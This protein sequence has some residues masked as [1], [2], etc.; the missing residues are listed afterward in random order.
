MGILGRVD[1]STGLHIL[2]LT[3]QKKLTLLQRQGLKVRAQKVDN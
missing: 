1:T 3:H 2:H